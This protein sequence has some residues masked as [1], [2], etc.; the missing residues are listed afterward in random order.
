MTYK[1]G[2]EV[3]I[4]L[5]EPDEQLHKVRQ[6]QGFNDFGERMWKVNARRG[7]PPTP[8]L[9]RDAWDDMT[10]GHVRSLGLA[11]LAAADYAENGD[12]S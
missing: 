3:T 2:R 10:V 5:P 9:Y 6:W 11:L 12:Q 1:F 8:V 4:T 7:H